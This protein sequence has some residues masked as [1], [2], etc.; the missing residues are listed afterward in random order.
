MKRVAFTI[1]Y[2]GLHHLK[3]NDYAKK[4]LSMF[5]LWIV[6]EGASGN[7]GSTAWCKNYPRLPNSTDGTR[8]YLFDL[9]EL[10]PDKMLISSQSEE[11]KSKDDMVNQAIFILK[12]QGIKKCFLWE[13]D[14]DE[15]W[16]KDQLVIAESDLILQGAKTGEFLCNYF[17]SFDLIVR[18][19]WGE[20]RALPYRRLWRWEGERFRSHE[21]P[22]LEGGNG[23]TILI[24]ER[25]D[26]FA[27]CF[28]RDVYFKSQY[29]GGHEMIYGPWMNLQLSGERKKLKF[30]LPISYLFGRGNYI[31]KSNT[32]IHQL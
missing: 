28:E 11:W 20:G 21:P 9:S 5:D 12:S 31:G 19:D 7:G 10:Y 2:N 30:P 16:K 25:F 29:Y 26:H 6:I 17:L 4:I 13:I 1:I 27:Y 22:E 18:G 23:K 32:Y 8:K 14:A 24:E 15:Q 3:H